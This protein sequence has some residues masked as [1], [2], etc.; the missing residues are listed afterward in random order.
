[1]PPKASTDPLELGAHYWSVPRNVTVSLVAGHQRERCPQ[2][3]QT[4]RNCM[5]D[6]RGAE[7]LAQVWGNGRRNVPEDVGQV[8]LA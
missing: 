5:D 7:P 1:M 3:A 2:M 4:E 6:T 8:P